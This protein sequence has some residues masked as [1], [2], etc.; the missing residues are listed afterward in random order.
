[1]RRVA[2]VYTSVGSHRPIF[3]GKEDK[4]NDKDNDKDNYNDKD[5]Y[6]E[7]EPLTNAGGEKLRR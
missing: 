6:T 1:M 5:K 7:N 4:Y 2:A 3:S